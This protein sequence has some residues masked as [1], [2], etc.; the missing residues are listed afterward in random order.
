MGNTYGEWGIC[1]V[2]FGKAGGYG[3]AAG[4]GRRTGAVVTGKA[5]SGGGPVKGF[6]LSSF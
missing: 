1:P 4:G 3:P 5:D 2:A 6:R